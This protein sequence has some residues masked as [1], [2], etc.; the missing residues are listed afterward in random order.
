MN[1][2]EKNMPRFSRISSRISSLC[3]VMLVL[4]TLC[5][6]ALHAQAA[7][8]PGATLDRVR[9]TGKLTLGYYESARP[10]TFKGSSGEPDGYAIALCRQIAAAVGEE[11]HLPN[12]A[13][14]FVEVGP[15]DRFN[16]VKEGRVDLLCGPSVPTLRNRTDVS[17]SIPIL[18]SGTGVLMR[19][20]GPAALRDL[21]ETGQTASG[22][23][24]RGSPMV[25]VLQRRTF[26]VVQSSLAEK[27]VNERRDELRVNSAVSSVP[28][29]ETGVQQVVDRRADAFFAERNVLLDLLR[30]NP[31]GSNLMV[32]D[33]Q[34]DHEPMTFALARDDSD[35]RLLVDK[36]LSDLY[37]SG[38][39]DAIYEKYFGAPDASMKQWF[40][41]TAVPE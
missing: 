40:R 18:E 37:R 39:I 5:A 36:V 26:A 8:T 41:R 17:F 14:Q 7:E 10:Y 29:L 32:L 22:P 35:F 38:K 9:T 25:A 16:A 28:N 23:I 33:R 31:A 30:N 21:L 15:D 27:L 6:P 34:F 24:W 4:L 11:L 13:I 20:D 3:G 1:L 19:R 12:L 2:M